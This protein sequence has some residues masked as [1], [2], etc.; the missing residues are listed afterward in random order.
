LTAAAAGPLHAGRWTLTAGMPSWAVAGHWRRLHLVD[1]DQ[2]HITWFGHGDPVEDQRD[3]LP[4]R[5]L[6]PGDAGRVRAYRRQAREGV[7]PPA[8]LWWVSGL[9]TLV[10]LDGH[11]RIVA[12]LFED[13]VPEVLVLAPAPQPRWAAA[14]QAH[15]LRAYG[16]RMAALDDAAGPA[17]VAVVN[18]RLAW[19]L[20]DIARQP[21]RTRAWPLPGGRVA[22]DRHTRE[23]APGWT[24]AVD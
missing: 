21:G 5:R 18:R 22:W 1:P 4:L 3:V 9:D 11:D 23:L 19:D 13:A 2:G 12:A 6:S 24:G 20:A 8:V 7:L 14:V 16:G 17:P 10:V 15:A